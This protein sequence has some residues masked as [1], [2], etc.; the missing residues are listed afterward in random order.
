M[1]LCRIICVLP[2]DE[3]Q[4]LVQRIDV[5]R[6]NPVMAAWLGINVPQKKRATEALKPTLDKLF[7]EEA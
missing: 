3:I 6:R 2:D 7:D 1:E 4:R 5:V